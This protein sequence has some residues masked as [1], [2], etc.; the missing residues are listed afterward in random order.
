MRRNTYSCNSGNTIHL[1]QLRTHPR[2]PP[3]ELPTHDAN[4]FFTDARPRVK[5][6][7]LMKP[8][9]AFEE[10]VLCLLPT[11]MDLNEGFYHLPFVARRLVPGLSADDE[12]FVPTCRSH[13]TF[14]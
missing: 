14:V 5:H 12:L 6:M 3:L 4:A 11:L 9:Q 8:F 10:P 1:L 7:L 2:L 13:D